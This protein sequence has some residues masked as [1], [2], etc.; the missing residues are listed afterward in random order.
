MT[1]DRTVLLG[2]IEA[3]FL[4]ASAAA[5]EVIETGAFRVHLGHADDPFYRTV[6][7]PT[8]LPETSGP[9]AWAPAI[10]AMRRRFAAAGRK[11][12]LEFIEERWP[13]LPA[14]L[15]AAGFVADAR[16]PVMVAAQPPLLESWKPRPSSG[17]DAARI[18]GTSDDA[19]LSAYLV[20]VHGSFG[21]ALAP[22]TIAREMTR[23]KSDVASGRCLVAVI[24]D[25]DGTVVAG[26]SLI[27]IGP[28]A[29]AT[30]ELAGVW[31]G[32]GHRRRGLGRAACSALL[33]HFFAAGG[34][35]VWL[36][37]E[38]EEALALYTSLDFRRIGWQCNISAAET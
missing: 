34:R 24:L 6:A 22:A 29:A 7:V 25:D 36:G 4:A 5:A 16:L 11:P 20:A 2:L 21:Q 18:L 35:L 38:G 10:E 9:L 31:T 32:A 15:A 37:A 26:A 23:L 8:R 19:L 12:R 3:Q 17:S 14:A 13:D 27:G 30:A 28:G 33:A 1:A